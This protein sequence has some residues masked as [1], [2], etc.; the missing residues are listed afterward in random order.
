[1]RKK[2]KM[3]MEGPK[4]KNAKVEN[5]LAGTV[6]TAGASRIVAHKR[7]DIDCSAPN[8][9]KAD[10]DYKSLSGPL[11]GG[12]GVPFSQEINLCYVLRKERR[13]ENAKMLLPNR[14]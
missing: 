11:Q 1:M 6:S 4:M 2:G 10:R 13:G 14:F 9:S 8:I 12:F 5:L 7:K 3:T